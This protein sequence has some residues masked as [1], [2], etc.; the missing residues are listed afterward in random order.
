MVSF[1]LQQGIKGFSA[2]W[3]FGYGVMID[4][5]ICC[6]K[7][8]LFFPTA[9]PTKVENNEM[10]NVAHTWASGERKYKGGSR[11]RGAMSF[12]LVI[13]FTYEGADKKVFLLP[14][15]QYYYDNIMQSSSNICIVL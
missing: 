3:S 9:Q 4:E 1:T 11:G 5:I 15:L 8:F 14:I 6:I 2:T 13:P 7:H 12:I 10:L